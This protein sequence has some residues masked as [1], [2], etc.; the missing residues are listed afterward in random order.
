MKTHRCRNATTIYTMIFVLILA[1]VMCVIPANVYAAGQI[2][3]DLASIEGV[4]DDFPSFTF[5]L[6][7]VGGYDGPDFVLDPYYS[8]VNVNIPNKE[9]YDK[10]K[11]AGDPTWEEAWLKSA[12]ILA[13][14]IKHPTAGQKTPPLVQ[15]FTGVNPGDSMSYSSE[16]NALF[17][18]IGKT[19]T[20]NNKNYTPVPIFVRTLNGTET[21]TIDAETKIKVEPV[22][23]E[24]SLMKVWEDDNDKYDI[25]PEAI[26]VGIYYGSQ[27]I[28]RV[29]LGGEDGEWTF[30]W[31]SEETGDTYCYI[32]EDE[33]G[34]IVRKDFTPGENDDAW[35]V[36]EFTKADQIKDS[37][38]RA[39]SDNL[40][41][42][43]PV[44]EKKTSDTLELFIINNPSNYNPPHDNPPKKPKTGDYSRLGIW[45]AAAAAAAILLI[46][47]LIRRRNR[48]D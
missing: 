32:Y 43:K 41:Y 28:D 11:K 22:V 9:E 37:E 26:E 20:Y 35:G 15:T 5:E 4:G 16:E 46:V 2:N 14:H 45:I 8:D 7:R 1:A 27:L 18:L 6:Y 33:D 44:Y 39:E 23:F 21:Y 25:R 36:R 47:L 34:S 30:K 17:L 24:H 38:A 42:Y 29:V 13:N 3:V 12:S 31:K 40:K 48:E 10:T 19:V